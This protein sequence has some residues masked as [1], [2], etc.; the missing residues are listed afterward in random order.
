MGAGFLLPICIKGKSPPENRKGLFK[1]QPQKLLINFDEFF[2]CK[3]SVFGK[4]LNNIY[5]LR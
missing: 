5:S 1:K 3:S 2:R 4:D